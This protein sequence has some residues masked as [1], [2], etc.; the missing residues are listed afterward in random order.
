M[1]YVFE[2]FDRAGK[3]VRGSVEAG[4]ESEATEKLRSQGMFVSSVQEYS[5]GHARGKM[6]LPSV[7]RLRALAMV[8]RQMSLLIAT[9]TTVVD[10][11]AAVERQV[12]DQKVRQTIS[13]VRSRVEEGASL[14]EAMGAHPEL[15]D[16]VSCSLIHAGETGGGMEGMLE[17]LAG[18][19]RQQ[20]K[21]VSSVIGSMVY[22]LLLIV[23]SVSVIVLMM[24]FVLPRFTEMFEALDAPL[25]ATTQLLMTVSDFMRT[26][27][28]GIIPAIGIG[29]FVAWR[30]IGT[31]K[32]R[33]RAEKVLLRMPG[34]G[35]IVISLV[36]ARMV[37]LLGVLIEARVPLLEALE[38]TR[39]SVQSRHFCALLEG[40]AERVSQGETLSSAFE[41]DALVPVSVSE[42]IG[43]GEKSG[44][45]GNVMSSLAEFMDEDNEVVV[46]SLSSIVEPVI[47]VVL[48]VVVGFVAISMFLPLFDLTSM[49]QQGG[50]K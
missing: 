29:G 8:T 49:T 10:A 6:R 12:K 30:A 50:G 35:K 28:M 23:V 3:V 2:A 32:G 47:L 31:D 16:T 17:R 19:A 38:L 24:T 42:S 26:Y 21:L 43:N 20:E 44:R 18:L 13:A 25:P 14:S 36:V 5:A 46:R 11:L 48:G 45:L 33:E 40:A 15:F 9:G 4:S 27:W 37:R 41:G 1:K 7:K 39:A 34:I 22:P